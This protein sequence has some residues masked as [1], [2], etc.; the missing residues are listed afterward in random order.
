M[1]PYHLVTGKDNQ[2][3]FYYLGRN[4]GDSP[5]MLTERRFNSEIKNV[6]LNA[7]FCAILCSSQLILHNIEEDHSNKNK[8]EQTFPADVFGLNDAVITCHLLTQDFL[9]FA[10]DVSYMIFERITINCL[11]N[12]RLDISFTFHWRSGMFVLNIGIQWEFRNSIAIL[13]E[14]N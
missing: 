13:R 14:P 9:I 1:G 12:F 7:D 11:L 8:R 2:V 4:F 3:W 10:T 6:K 5:I